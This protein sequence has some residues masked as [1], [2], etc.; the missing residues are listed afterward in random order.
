MYC[1]ISWACSSPDREY[2]PEAPP[3]DKM[4]LTP[5]DWQVAMAEARASQF[6]PSP[7]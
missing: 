6:W 3:R 1:P 4:I 2:A 5:T 7:S